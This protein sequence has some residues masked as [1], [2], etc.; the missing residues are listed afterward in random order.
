MHLFTIGAEANT[1]LDVPEIVMDR[2]ED[3]VDGRRAVAKP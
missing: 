3:V 1:F 2:T